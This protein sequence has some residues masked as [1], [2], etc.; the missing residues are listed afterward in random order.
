MYSDFHRKGAKNAKKS[1]NI[2]WENLQSAELAIVASI[3]YSGRERYEPSF[4]V[5]RVSF[6]FFAPLR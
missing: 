2:V 6:A 3:G 1:K 4:L 5:I